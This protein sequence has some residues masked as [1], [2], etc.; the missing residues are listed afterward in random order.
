VTVNQPY[1]IYKKPEL[2]NASLI[3]GWDDDAGSLGGGVIDYLN[4]HLGG[5]E[6][7]EIEPTTFFPLGGVSIEDDVAQFPESK[8]YYCQQKNLVLFKSNSPRSEWY[9]FLNIILDV[10]ENVCQVKEV[11][12]V[13][14]SITL[15]AHTTPRAPFAIANSES[16]KA[17]VHGSNLAESMDYETPPGQRPTLSSFFLW[18]AM[19][20]NISAASLWIPVP[21]YL[22]SVEDPHACRMAIEFFDRRFGLGIDFTDIDKEIAQHNERLA[23]VINKSPGLGDSIRKLE[24]NIGLTAEESEQLLKAIAE[25]FKKR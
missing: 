21:F 12:T 14:V 18:C 10:G 2:R 9:R 17:I 15:T 25:L 8:F 11:Y 7:G 4:I 24:S 6:F 23:R 19:Q 22:V 1:R 16:M 3:I 5:E 20:R 13:G